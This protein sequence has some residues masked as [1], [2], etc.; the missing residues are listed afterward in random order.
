MVSRQARCSASIT[1]SSQT[2]ATAG[3]LTYVVAFSTGPMI[4]GYRKAQRLIDSAL[5]SFFV[6]ASYKIATSDR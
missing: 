2:Q 3:R 5:G 1:A 6:F 4:A